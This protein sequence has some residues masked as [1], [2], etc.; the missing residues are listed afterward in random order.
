MSTTIA[1]VLAEVNENLQADFTE[2]QIRPK[3]QWV[4]NDLSKK[5]MLVGSDATQTLEANDKTLAFPAGYR[6]MIAITLTNTDTEVA[7]D[8]LTKLKGGHEHYR[9]LLQNDETVGIP[10]HYSRFNQLFFLWR[11]SDTDYTVLIEYYKDHAQLIEAA[12][13]IE[14]DDTFTDAINAG[15]T[16]RMA[17]SKGRSR[18]VGIWGPDYIEERTKKS[19]EFYRQPRIVEAGS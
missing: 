7:Q 3:L 16:Y 17:M 14:F 1:E 13:V 10:S 6:A 9:R 11:P 4:L 2:D 15:T 8:P 12:G 18:M 19:N 5:D